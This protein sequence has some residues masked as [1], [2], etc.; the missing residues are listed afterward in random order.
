MTPMVIVRCAASLPGKLLKWLAQ[1]GLSGGED[2]P[3]KAEEEIK[4][5]E[6]ARC[7]VCGDCLAE[8]PSREGKDQGCLVHETGNW[9]SAVLLWWLAGY[10][11][12]HSGG[13]LWMSE[14]SLSARC[15]WLIKTKKASTAEGGGT[16][17]VLEWGEAARNEIS[18]AEIKDFIEQ[19]RMGWSAERWVLGAKPWTGAALR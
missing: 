2:A 16:E 12:Q 9:L 15:R 7:G 14:H 3:F 1:L 6:A 10:C 5:L 18:E 17:N 19:A 11:S 4:R 13:L 8:G